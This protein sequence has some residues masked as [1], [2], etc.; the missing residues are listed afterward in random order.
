MVS[1]V[2]RGCDPRR[3]RGTIEAV[4][5]DRTTTARAVL[6]PTIV[7][8]GCSSRLVTR[9]AQAAEVVHCDVRATTL[10]ELATAVATSRPLVIVLPTVEYWAHRADYDERAEDVNA[11]VVPV[12]SDKI[13]PYE[14][15]GLFMAAVAE[16][17]RRRTRSGA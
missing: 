1:S 4:K 12:A 16:A 5:S 9:C 8:A 15:E 13:D 7:V 2:T 11:T 17:M 14:L 3:I 10:E 6:P